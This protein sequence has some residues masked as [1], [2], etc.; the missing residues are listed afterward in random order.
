MQALGDICPL[1]MDSMCVVVPTAEQACTLV[2][3][4]K[5]MNSEQP[6]ALTE[7]EVVR[8]RKRSRGLLS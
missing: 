6:V 3:C 4:I 8:I 2:L 1:R 5:L 7:T